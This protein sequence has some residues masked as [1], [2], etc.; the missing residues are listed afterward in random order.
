LRRGIRE[1]QGSRPAL[2]VTGFRSPDHPGPPDRA[3]FAGWGGHPMT[4]S[5]D[6]VS[7]PTLRRNQ[8]REGWAT[9]PTLL[10]TRLVQLFALRAMKSNP[11]RAVFIRIAV[12]GDRE[13]LVVLGN[14]RTLGAWVHNRLHRSPFL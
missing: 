10:M 4:R 6:W 8:K 1:V 7:N 3:V 13:P 11:H 9:R 14:S 12:L 2:A 5:P